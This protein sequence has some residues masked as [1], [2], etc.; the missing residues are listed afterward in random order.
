M[1]G[2]PGIG[3]LE[4]LMQ[5]VIESE[6]KR[7]LTAG[8]CAGFP[9]LSKGVEKLAAGLEKV[10]AASRHFTKRARYATEDAVEDVVH[11]VKHYPAQS[12]G[13]AFGAG[14]ILGMALGGLCRKGGRK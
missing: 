9:G 10:K 8:I 12:L 13:I 6:E 7:N 4:S 2:P 14:A 11:R 1:R 3:N 5:T